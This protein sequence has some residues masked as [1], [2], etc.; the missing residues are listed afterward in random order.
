MVRHSALWASAV[1]AA[2]LLVSSV[3]AG[4]SASQVVDYN[5]GTVVN[6]YWGAAYTNPSAALGTPDQT[7]NVPNLYDSG[8]NQIAF[9][10][11]SA[12][13]PFNASYNPQ[14]IVAIQNAGGQLTLKLSAPVTIGSG[15]ALGIHAAA[16]L[17][18]TNYPS[19][20]AGSPA[21]T[22]TD[23][24]QADLQVSQD[25]THWVDLGDK[26]F[27]APTNIFSNATDPIGDTPGTTPANLFQPFYGGLNSFNGENFSQVLATLNGSAGGNWFD[28][29]SVDLSN[30]DYV[31]FSTSAGEKMFIDAVV[32]DTGSSSGTGSGPGS[33]PGTG[34]IT[35]VPL[36]TGLAMGLSLAPL[37]LLILRR[38]QVGR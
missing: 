1:G 33:G 8:G 30:V 3:R 34:P 23:P 11:N 32:A 10:D 19:G 26:T 25:G 6:S 24:R 5:A 37:G 9:A 7:Q 28:L 35:A 12:I 15:A 16:G 4:I 14:N 38:R 27:E 13:T 31:R 17:E 21:T 2:A 18:D 36:P 20:Q 29:S 22:Y